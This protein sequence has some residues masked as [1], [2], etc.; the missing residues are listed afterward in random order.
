MRRTLAALLTAPLLGSTL[1]G[2]TLMPEALQPHQLW[3]L[4]R[5]PASGRDDAFFSIPDPFQ[6][7]TAGL[8]EESSAGEPPGG[9]P[10][11]DFADAVD[12]FE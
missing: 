1:A 10:T 3:K 12:P 4:N 7:E 2:C 6:A 11:S 9:D 5:Q 8:A